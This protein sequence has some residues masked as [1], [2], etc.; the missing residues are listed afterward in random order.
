MEIRINKEAI[1]NFTILLHHNRSVYIYIILTMLIYIFYSL[2]VL[3][4]LLNIIIE[5]NNAELTFNTYIIFQ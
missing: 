5:T 4:I 2:D 3:G 1:F